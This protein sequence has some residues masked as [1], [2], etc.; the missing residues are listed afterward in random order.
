MQTIDLKK[1]SDEELVIHVL[2]VD[3]DSYREVVLRY[4]EKLSH[5]VST[6]T[7]DEA[8]VS[9]VVQESFIN[10]YVHLSSFNT[11]LK[12]SSWIYRIAHNIAF[13]YFGR[14]NRDLHLDENIEFPSNDNIVL[15]YELMEL[16]KEVR[17]HLQGIPIQ[18]SE[19]LSLHFLEGY[20]YEEIS[21]ILGL[22]VGTVGTRIN[23]A[24]NLLKQ[25]YAK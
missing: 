14:K 4:Q 18:Y 7:R 19:P 3:R 8:I 20:S 13:N 24:K 10:A 15:E 1:L 2:R 22:P 5:Y 11:G 23:R 21:S 16:S 12:F 17:S 9:D 6:F 25:K